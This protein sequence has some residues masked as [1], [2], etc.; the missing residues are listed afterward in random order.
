MPAEAEIG[1]RVCGI[2]DGVILLRNLK[3]LKM[4]RREKPVD[5]DEGEMIVEGVDGKALR[6]GGGELNQSCQ[7]GK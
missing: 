2:R 3:A 7:E 1:V 4:R 5:W 6:G